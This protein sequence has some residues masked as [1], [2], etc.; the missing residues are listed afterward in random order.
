MCDHLSGKANEQEWQ[1]L[2]AQCFTIT[3]ES[4]PDVA[5]AIEYTSSVCKRA[6]FDVKLE[7]PEAYLDT[8]DGAYFK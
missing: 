1:R 2:M 5:Y 8:T 3:C 7:L 4:P 6:G